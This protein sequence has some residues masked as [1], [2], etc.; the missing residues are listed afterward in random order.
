[1]KWMG[2]SWR[3]LLEVPVDYLEVVAEMMRESQNQQGGR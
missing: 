1:M 2:W 3:E